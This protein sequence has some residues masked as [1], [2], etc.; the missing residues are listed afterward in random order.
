MTPPTVSTPLVSI[1]VL[2]WNG[3]HLLEMCLDACLDQS[4][5]PIELMVVDNASTDGTEGFVVSRYGDRVR[6]VALNQNNG[7]ARGN[8]EGLRRAHGDLLVTL[9]NDTQVAPN[10]IEELVGAI[11]QSDTIGACASRQMRMH[12]PGEFDAIGVGIHTNGSSFGVGTGEQDQGQYDRPLEVFGAHGASAMYRRQAL[13]DAG[14]F[15]EDFFAY[16]E[17]FDLNW[18]LRLLGW[19]CVYVPGA[20]LAHMGGASVKRKPGLMDYLKIRNRFYCLLKNYPIGVLPH[21]LPSILKN[22]VGNA[23]LAAVRGQSFRYTARRDVFPAMGRMLKRR[24]HI[25]R[26]RRMSDDE[27]RS[28]LNTPWRPWCPSDTES[29]GNRVQ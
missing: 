25:Q 15:D 4:Y 29:G 7:Y 28:W 3:R 24:K 14:L 13:E 2:S 23:Y 27:F 11:G 26:K 12:D 16:E 8:N 18:R 9:N 1:V 6:F 20:R 5:G 10:W 22:E 21:G 17:E 19:R